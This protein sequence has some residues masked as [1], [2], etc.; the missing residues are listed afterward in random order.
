M[1]KGKEDW[2][3]LPADLGEVARQIADDMVEALPEKQKLQLL[4]CEKGPMGKRQRQEL[5][6]SL[7]LTMME[8]AAWRQEYARAAIMDPIAAAKIM[9]QN[10][11]K[12][13]EEV[14][15]VTHKHVIVVPATLS[16]EA[17]NEGQQI[18]QKT[19]EEG[20]GARSPWG[21]ITDAE[22]VESERVS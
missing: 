16:N 15:E 6:Q 18:T 19:L 20:W 3:F 1:G 9:N 12:A 10:V 4:H 2:W 5:W 7:S 8:S 14:R 17:W 22:E 11:P 13:I 21:N